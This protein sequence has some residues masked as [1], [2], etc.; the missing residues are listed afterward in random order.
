M[1]QKGKGWT[2]GLIEG[3]I[4]LIHEVIDWEN[5]MDLDEAFMKLGVIMDN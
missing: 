4:G 1:Y 3:L 2:T 5:S